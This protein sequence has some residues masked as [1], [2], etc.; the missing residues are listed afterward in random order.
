MASQTSRTLET[1]AL[2]KSLADTYQQIC[3]DLIERLRFITTNFARVC[4]LGSALPRSTK[5]DL[6]KLYPNS[7]FCKLNEQPNL[8]ID[9]AD[10]HH[11][12][13]PQGRIAR[14]RKALSSSG[15]YIGGCWGGNT[16]IELQ[17]ALIA[18]DLE[19]YEMAHQRLLPM[20]RPATI[21]QLIHQGGF[22]L[23]VSDH[24]QFTVKYENVRDLLRDIYHFE[25]RELLGPALEKKYLK[26]LERNFALKN[27]CVTLD[28]VW[29][30]GWT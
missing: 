11:D 8:I 18:A 29:F 25:G 20:L 4:V 28:W 22:A 27:R 12:V 30:H 16:L 6:Q 24:D 5:E 19:V 15:L 3:D 1:T 26:A 23:P 21:A 14:M 2:P 10:L 7:M 17:K 13:D 9:W